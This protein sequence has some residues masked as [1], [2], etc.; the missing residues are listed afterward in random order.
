VTACFEKSTIVRFVERCE[1]DLV[2]DTVFAGLSPRSRFLR[3]HSPVR[4]LTPALRRALV[5]IDG[6]RRMAVAAWC[7][8]EPLGIARITRTGPGSA[9][10]AAAVVD[11]W[12]RR[13]LGRRLVTAA[14][15]L[16][17][18]AGIGELHGS[19]LPENRAM[20]ELVRTTFPLALRH[21]DDGTIQ[22]RIPLGS[23]AWTIT[24]EDVYASLLRR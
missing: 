8:D 17:E 11:T 22:I 14:V 3:F 10:L 1:S 6:E 12:Q 23:A 16:A 7:G 15:G 4:A 13:G 5:P 24:E 20:L 9:D 2:V 21:H 18:R 19:V